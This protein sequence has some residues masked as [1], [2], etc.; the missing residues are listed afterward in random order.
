MEDLFQ[1]FRSWLRETESQ[2]AS[3]SP[4]SSEDPDRGRQLQQAKV[5][6]QSWE[7]VSVS[8][9]LCDLLYI[10]QVPMCMYVTLILVLLCSTST[11]ELLYIVL[12]GMT[13]L[14]LYVCRY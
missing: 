10:I 3:L 14:Y 5:P 8:L 11:C 13:S 6:Y 4:P 2:L 1:R 7:T 9:L 12:V